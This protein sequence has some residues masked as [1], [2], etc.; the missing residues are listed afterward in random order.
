MKSFEYKVLLY[1]P[2]VNLD[3]NLQDLNFI[4]SG[5]WEVCAFVPIDNTKGHLIFKREVQ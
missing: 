2:Y 3:Q 4:G 5:G 1:K